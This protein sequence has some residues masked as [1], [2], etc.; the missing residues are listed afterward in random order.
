MPVRIGADC[1]TLVNWKCLEPGGNGDLVAI[2]FYHGPDPT[3]I[4]LA[5]SAFAQCSHQIRP[6]FGW[7][8]GLSGPHS[9]FLPPVVGTAAN[10]PT[11]STVVSPRAVWAETATK[12]AEIPA[13][14]RNLG[15]TS[16]VGRNGYAEGA[17]GEV[18]LRADGCIL[19]MPLG[20]RSRGGASTKGDH[21]VATTCT[22]DRGHDPGRIGYRDAEDLHPVGMPVG[23]AL[24]PLAGPAQR[25]KRCGPTCWACA[26][27]GRPAAHS[28]PATTGCVSSIAIRLSACG[29]CSGKKDRLAAAEAAA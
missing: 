15:P 5:N 2:H 21:H 25:G 22:D 12:S 7:I 14:S 18:G 26:R 20:A 6:E 4:L 11:V 19:L 3:V 27:V 9:P 24:P 10:S 29:A 23:C 13:L 28:R 16:T 8:G 1:H 17:G